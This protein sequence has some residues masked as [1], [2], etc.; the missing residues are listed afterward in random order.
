VNTQTETWHGTLGGYTNHRCRCPECTVANRDYN[1]KKRASYAEK[2]EAGQMPEWRH[3]TQS[4][5]TNWGCRCES[6]RNARVNAP[7]REAGGGRCGRCGE[8]GHNVRTCQM[9]LTG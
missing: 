4:G 8:V 6:C 3:G 1:A 9:E 5:Y 2:R 7:A